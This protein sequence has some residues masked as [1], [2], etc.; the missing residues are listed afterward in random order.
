MKAKKAIE[1]YKSYVEKYASAKS[2]FEQKMAE[3]SQVFMNLSW[4]LHPSPC[5]HVI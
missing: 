3:T 4:I 1:T 5:V 2:D